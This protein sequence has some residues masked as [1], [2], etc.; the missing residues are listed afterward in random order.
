MAKSQSKLFENATQ[1]AEKEIRRA[2]LMQ[3][4]ELKEMMSFSLTALIN[5]SRRGKA[6]LR[7]RALG[8]S[9]GTRQSRVTIR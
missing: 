6:N 2:R 4:R 7:S 8:N 3:S 9:E 5:T 1:I